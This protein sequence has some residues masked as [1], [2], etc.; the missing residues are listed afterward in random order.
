MRLSRSDGADWRGGGARHDTHQRRH[1][2]LRIHLYNIHGLLRGGTLEIG[3]DADNGGQTIYVMELAHGLAESDKVEHVDLFTRRVEDPDLDPAYSAET[4]EIGPKCT[5][6]RIQ[7]GGKRYLLKEKLWPHLEEFATNAIARIRERGILPDWIHSHYADAAFVAARVSR[8]L[9][10]PF[11]H[12]AHSLGRQKLAAM[13]RAG[14]DRDELLKRYSFPARFDAEERALAE[15]EFIVTSTNQ[16]ISTWEP[17]ANF[18]RGIFHPIAPG[19]DLDRFYPYFEDELDTA[20]CGFEE[21]KALFRLKESLKNFYLH[22]DKPFILAIARADKRKNM[23]GLI[24]AYGTDPQ[25]QA[26]A[27]LAVFAGV[28]EDIQT[29]PEGERETLTE[30]L[31]LM[32][33]YNLYGKLAIPKK[34]GNK[35]QIPALY[36][37][38]ALQKGVYVNVALQEN[39]G[40]TILEAGASGLPVVVTNSGGPPEIL[41]SCRHGI[42]VDPLDNSAIQEALKRILCDRSL[43]EEY[44]TNGLRYVRERY[45]WNSH[46]SRYLELVEENLALSRGSGIKLTQRRPKSRR[47]RSAMT[48][49]VTDIDGTLILPERE[50]PGLDELRKR[51]SSRPGDLVLAYASGRNTALV[52]QAIAEYDLPIPDICIASV[53]SRIVYDLETEE[54]DSGWKAYIG[55]RW[56]ADRIRQTL[57]GLSWLERQPEEAQTPAKLSYF[58][59]AGAFDAA[60]LRKVLGKDFYHLTIARSHD[61]FLDILPR[62]A[63]KGRAVR[64]IS[65]ILGIPPSRVLCFGDSGNDI[66]MLAP[67]FRGVVV[68]NHEAAL[69]ELRGTR[70]ILFA[71]AP[72]AE[73]V[74]EGLDRLGVSWKPG[75]ERECGEGHQE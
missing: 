9:G 34:T 1:A 61:R 46:V 69:E 72:A 45:S 38:C 12:T 68:G 27:N 50:N 59:E 58:C 5:I 15:A 28:R 3:R 73:G 51:M 16:E 48:L 47:L 32:D 31:L 22:A 33:K 39:F 40:L 74:I 36:R 65:K 52:R 24:H 37:L 67:P 75:G 8:H 2:V 4:E 25:L 63:S 17:Y 56:Y 64:Y 13:L 42:E 62:R 11:A 60:E 7:C 55:Y 57:A 41:K 10:T 30:I 70:G 18:D 20:R 29:M 19:L 44:S 49:V 23:Q 21:K 71:S 53:G 6:H 43:W 66:D 14:W 26:L 54:E 35:S